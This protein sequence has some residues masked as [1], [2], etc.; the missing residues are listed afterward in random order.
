MTSSPLTTHQVC[1]ERRE[2]RQRAPHD[3]G[4][5]EEALAAVLADQVARRRG[6][7]QV[8]PARGTEDHTLNG[9]R[10][11]ERLKKSQI[12]ILTSSS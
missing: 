3:G 11:V 12:N 5:G 6:G 2:E 4:E 8:P 1:R 9:L 10:P 7:R